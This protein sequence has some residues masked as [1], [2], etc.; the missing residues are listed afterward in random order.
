MSRQDKKTE[1]LKQR[2]GKRNSIIV[3]PNE[4]PKFEYRVKISPQIT[5]NTEY[6]LDVC[7]EIKK[8]DATIDY[9]VE[10]SSDLPISGNLVIR[11]NGSFGRSETFKFNR[12]TRP[13]DREENDL[14]FTINSKDVGEVVLLFF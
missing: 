2:F 11:L 7:Y 4:V 14:L 13:D 8:I 5:K 12:F 9:K 10:F 6:T 3:Y 1:L